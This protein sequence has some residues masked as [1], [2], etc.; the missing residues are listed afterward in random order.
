[1]RLLLL[2]R[3]FVTSFGH[4]FVGRGSEGLGVVFKL[5]LVVLRHFLES[6]LAS[7]LDLDVFV[8]HSVE[9]KGCSGVDDAGVVTFLD[10]GVEEFSTQ[11][12]QL[13]FD[14]EVVGNH[15]SLSIRLL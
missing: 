13:S 1:M 2:N 6:L 9:S 5:V 10:L 11:I 14:D 3:L 4:I 15:L 12:L 7:V 8:V